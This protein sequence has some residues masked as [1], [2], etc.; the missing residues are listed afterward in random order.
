MASLHYFAV[1]DNHLIVKKWPFDGLG[2]FT[3]IKFCQY[4]T[5]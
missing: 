3:L 4:I 2:F 5:K 1:F